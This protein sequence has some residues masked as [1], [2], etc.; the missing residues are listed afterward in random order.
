MA[1]YQYGRGQLPGSPREAFGGA[2]GFRADEDNDGLAIAAITQILY[3]Q[4]YRAVALTN[5]IEDCCS[6]VRT[7]YAVYQSQILSF[8]RTVERFQERAREQR[9]SRAGIS[10]ISPASATPALWRSPSAEAGRSRFLSA[11]Y[12]ADRRTNPNNCSFE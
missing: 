11:Q 10:E 1:S 2:P 6:R 8:D 12:T 9:E 3:H 7:S 4:H 5:S